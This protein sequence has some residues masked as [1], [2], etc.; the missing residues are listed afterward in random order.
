MCD[1][2][3]SRGL[4]GWKRRG[5]DK[6]LT[7]RRWALGQ[8]TTRAALPLTRRGGHFS[9]VSERRK[10]LAQALRFSNPL[11]ARDFWS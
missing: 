6:A 2:S 8:D 4:R 10:P 11:M 9:F 7:L 5:R 1:G 3:S